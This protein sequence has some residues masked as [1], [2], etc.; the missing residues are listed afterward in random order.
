MY[1]IVIISSSVRTGR[2]SHR[3][4]IYLENYIAQSGLGNAEILDLYEYQFPIFSERLQYL[5]NPPD[6]VV[7]FAE[8]IKSADGVIVVTPEYNGGYPAA[9]KNVIDLLYP[10]WKRKPIGIST[11]SAGTF[12]GSQVG[13]SLS[14]T[15]LKIG[16]LVTPAVFRVS[17]V[18]KAYDENG[19]PVEKP[20]TDK[21]A[22]MFLDEFF[23]CVEAHRRM[24]KN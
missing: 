12:G 17:S 24:E 5:Q 10:E 23:W 21:F 15:L 9:L 19:V 20:T 4:A 16:A 14:F 2:N 11:V 7:Q 22:K 3:V 18:Q 13:T 6:N 8:K 1:N